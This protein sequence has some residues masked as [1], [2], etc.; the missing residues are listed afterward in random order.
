MGIHADLWPCLE[1]IEQLPRNESVLSDVDPPPLP[2]HPLCC[3]AL[4]YA[5][6]RLSRAQSRHVLTV[7]VEKDAGRE[8]SSTTC[9]VTVGSQEVFPTEACI[10]V[11]AMREIMARRAIEQSELMRDVPLP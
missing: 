6:Q 9:S 2:D 1:A 11:Q 4:S 10:G 5:L 3:I 8:S 7:K